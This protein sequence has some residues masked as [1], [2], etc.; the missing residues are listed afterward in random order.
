M[1]HRMYLG[2]RESYFLSVWQEL[3][4]YVL[5][6]LP[7]YLITQISQDWLSLK[8]SNN[9]NDRRGSDITLEGKH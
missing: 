3:N 7:V 5:D 8:Q 6:C 9:D 4:L 2:G 1:L